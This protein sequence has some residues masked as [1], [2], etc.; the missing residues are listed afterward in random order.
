MP[1]GTVKWFSN[2]KGYGFISP[3]EGGKDIFVHHS[4][5]VGE[6]FRSLREGERVTF[7]VAGSAKGLQA[8]NV[9][10]LYGA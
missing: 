5:I 4:D 8:V 10:R 1:T 3:D 2:D 6:D 7:E 9:E